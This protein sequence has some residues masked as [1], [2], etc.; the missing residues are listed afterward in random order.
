MK[1]N[2]NVEQLLAITIRLHGQ[3]AERVVYAAGMACKSPEQYLV[4]LAKWTG[5]MSP[6]GAA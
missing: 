1:A 3:D 4:D 2:Q 5:R 6:G